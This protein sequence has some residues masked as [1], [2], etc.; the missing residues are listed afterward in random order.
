MLAMVGDRRAECRRACSS[1][2]RPTSARVSDAASATKATKQLRY[3]VGA[4]IAPGQT[5]RYAGTEDE[6]SMTSPLGWTGRPAYRGGPRT[7]SC[8]TGSRAAAR[9]ARGTAHGGRDHRR[10]AAPVQSFASLEPVEQVLLVV[11]PGGPGRAP[12]P[13]VSWCCGCAF[14]HDV[15][16][17][18]HRLRPMWSFIVAFFVA[19]TAREERYDALAGAG[20]HLRLDDLARPARLRVRGLEA[21]RRAGR[22][23]DGCWRW[24]SRPRRPGS[25][26][27]GGGRDQEQAVSSISAVSRASLSGCGSPRTCRRSYDRPQTSRSSTS[28]PA[29]GLTLDSRPDERARR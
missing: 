2:F 9:A 1:G 6:R 26:A 23:P 19:A 10:T 18:G 3:A 20:A 16:A 28:R 11:R 22:S 8:A 17:V 15:R 13:S 25:G 27:S 7:L 12:P 4:C 5:A 21:Q 14:R 24:R 29:W